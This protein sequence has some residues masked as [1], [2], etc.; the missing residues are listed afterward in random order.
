M[1]LYHETA[2][3]LTGS[4]PSSPSTQPH[5]QIGGSFKSRIFGSKDGSLKSPPAQIYALA[6]ESCKW[7]AVLKEVVENAQ[8]LQ[9]ERKLTPALSILLVHDFLVSKGGIALPASHGLRAAI[10]RHKARLTSEFTRARLRRRCATLAELRDQIEAEYLVS[11]GIAAHPRW[12]RVNTLKSSVDEQ[13][14]TTFK[15]FEVVPAVSD[16]ISG[17][18]MRK[19]IC[20]DGNVPNLIAVSPLSGVDCTKTEAYKAGK[21]I[22]QD[23]ASC[24]PAYLLDPRPTDE[25]GDVIDACAAPGNKTTHLAAILHERSSPQ[26]DGRTLGRNRVFAFEKDRFRAQ[27]LEKMVKIAGSDGFTVINRGVDFL[28]VDPKAEEYKNVG[29]LLLDPSCSGSGIVGRDEMPELH[30]P[31]SATTA[32]VGGGQKNDN[33]KG[34][35]KQQQGKRKRDSEDDD[36]DSSSNSKKKLAAGQTTTTTELIDDDGTTTL[37]SSDQEL[38]DRI[39]ALAGFQLTLL[40]HAFSFPA[41][42]R[43][44]YST[45][46]IYAGENEHVVMKALQSDIA[47]KRG[48]RILKREEQVAGMREWPVRG[49][50][51]ACEGDDAEEIA[52]GCVRAYRDD[53]RGVM[54]FFVA[55]FV[56]D[57]DKTAEGEADNGGPFVR[58]ELGRIVRDEN[59]IPT[60]KA[61]GE[62]AFDLDEMDDRESSA[63][64][65]IGKV[66]DAHDGEEGPFVRDEEGRIVRDAQGMPSLKPGPMMERRKKKKQKKKKAAAAAAAADGSGVPAAGFEDDGADDEW[67]GFED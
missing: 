64:Y 29:A 67:D 52:D 23:K 4:S 11:S 19:V 12:V 38:K 26:D 62:K 9:A 58:D 2:A 40:C 49:A 10:E 13:L 33:K 21:I 28:K 24:F 66:G 53:G 6:L 1:S 41:A 59:G 56:R 48:W 61:T 37:V 16:V 8:L 51:E 31:S 34:G 54:G 18:Q 14:E 42:K 63:E 43:I 45:C 46:S 32:K 44:S 50:V 20:L 60:L 30:L 36:E 39:S 17:T 22:L 57:D 27:T 7:S 15:D 3:I 55:G 5:S 35:N 25:R 47:K 65:Y